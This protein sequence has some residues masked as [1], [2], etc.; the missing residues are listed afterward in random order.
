MVAPVE[1]RPALQTVGPPLAESTHAFDVRHY[2][3]DLNLPMTSGAA[4]A[5]ERILFTSRL[6]QLNSITLMM[7]SLTCDS[8]K[9]NTT[10]LSFQYPTDSLIITLDAALP[11]G[12]SLALDIF[13]HR[14]SGIPNRGFFYYAHS[15]RHTLAFSCAAPYDARFWFPCYD[16]PFDKAEQGCAINVTVPDSLSVCS[17]GMLDSVVA[18]TL[19][20]TATYYWT[21]R[22]PIS[23][24]LMV[25]AVSKWVQYVQHCGSNQPDSIEVWS[26]CCPGDTPWVYANLHNVPDMFQ[27]FADTARFGRYPFERYGHVYCTGFPYGGMENQTLTML[28]LGQVN[29]ATI[30]HEM[31]HMWWGDM[32]TCVD[33]RNIWLNEGFANY[34]EAQYGEHQSGHASFLATMKSYASIYFNEDVRH[35]F[36]TYDPGIENVYA[37]GTIYCKGAWLQHMLRYVEGD[38]VFLQP[39]VFYRALRAYG[40]SFKYGCASSQDYQRIQEH[41]CGLDLGWFY[42]EWLYQA[43]YP[44]YRLAWS[45]ESTGTTSQSALRS[46]RS[47]WSLTP[48]P[49]PLTPEFRVI[50]NLSQNNGNNAPP[51]FHMPVQIKFWGHDPNSSRNSGRRNSGSCTLTALDTLVVLPVDTSPQI[52]TFSL[53]FRPDSIIFDPGKWILNKATVTGVEEQFIAHPVPELEMSGSSFVRNAAEFTVR[54]PQSAVLS[55]YDAAGR[56]TNRFRLNSGTTRIAWDCSSLPAGVYIVRLASGTESATKKLLVAR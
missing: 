4:Q 3:I 49:R 44:Q 55:F 50:V 24:Y 35:R 31:S 15:T 10:H 29:D 28:A 21:H 39:G 51:V 22:F 34:W 18:D 9:R 38:T 46:P 32:V 1:W 56:E 23:T 2:R 40:D 36:A 47:A 5:H 42:N 37:D 27:F 6:P 53:G 43:G 26:Y 14:R 20:H 52:D 12:E 41:Y 17:N 7:D 33:Y 8:V 54:S 30:S 16:E 48:D 45:A 13:Y 19:N 25:F 11:E